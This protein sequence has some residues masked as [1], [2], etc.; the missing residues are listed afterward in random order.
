MN[1]RAIKRQSKIETNVRDTICRGGGAGSPFQAISSLENST[2]P[3]TLYRRRIV[4]CRALEGGDAYD[5]PIRRRKRGYVLMM[6]QSEA[7]GAA[8]RG[9]ESID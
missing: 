2:C 9:G 3:P 5:G 6:N 7:G 8:G 1:S 4:E